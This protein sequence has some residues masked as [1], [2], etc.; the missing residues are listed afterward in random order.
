M[1]E[2]LTG[3]LPFDSNYDQSIIYSILNE[4]INHEKLKTQVPENIS[5]IV[6]KCLKKDKNERY[7]QV[8]ELMSEL[9]EIKKES[10]KIYSGIQP[11]LPDFLDDGYGDIISDK[12]I[13]VAREEELEK[14]GRFLDS[15]LSGKGR[16]VFVTGES[17]AGKTALVQKFSLYAQKMNPNLI[18]INGKCNAHTGF[19]DPYFPFIELL[20]LL[21]GDIESKYKAGVIS[22]E[23][24]LRLW[25]LTPATISAILENGAD[26]I[27]IFTNG[28]SLVSRA[29]EYWAGNLDW[30]I[31]LKKLVKYKS[32]LPA[33][34]TLQQRNI[35]EQYTRVIQSIAEEKPLLIVLNDLQWIDAGSANLFFHLARQI[36][37]SRILI[38]GLFRKTEIAIERDGKRHPMEP[39]FNELKRDYGEIEIDLDKIHGQKF[40]D[41]Y[42]DVEPN[43]LNVKF[44][45]T[46]FIQTKGHPLFT[47][48]L[49]REMKEHGMIVRDEAGR[50][51]EGKTFDWNRLP[52]RVDA[53]ITER[54]NRL[55]K[56]MRDIL[57][58]SCIQ[59]EE[60]A[61]EVTARFL[62]IDE[63]ELIRILSG[64]LE[65]LH[66]L[67]SAKGIKTL[68]KQRISM[69]IFRHIMFQ[70]YLYNSLDK[71]ERINL[72]EEVAKI[73]EE[74]YGEEVDEVS[75]QLAR[76]FQEAEIPEKAFEYLVKAGTRAVNFSA[77]EEIIFLFK[78]ALA[79]LQT[80]SE[81]AERDQYELSIQ[82]ALATAYQILIGFD[83]P[84]VTACCNRM[85]ELCEKMGDTPQNFY[86]QYFLAHI[87]WMLGNHN[88]A[89][90][91]T[92]QL[93]Q[94]AEKAKDAEKVSLTHCLQGSLSFYLGKLIPSLEHFKQMNSDYLTEKSSHLKCIV[95]YDPGLI[96]GINSACALWCLGYPDQANLQSQKMIK[97]ARLIDHSMNLVTCLSLDAIHRILRRDY[98]ICER[99]GEEIYGISKK[100]GFMLFIGGGLFKIGFA[101]INQ[102][103]VEE[104]IKKLHQ[105][106]EIYI[107]TGLG[108]TR[109]ELL[110]SFAEAYGKYGDI[111]RGMDFM[112]QAISLAQTGGEHYYEAELYRIKGELLL[113]EADKK[114]RKEIEKKAEEC[115]YQSITLAQKQMAKSFELR[116][117]TSL[118]RLLQKQ[119]KKKEAR[120]LLTNIYDWFTE[121]FETKDLIEAKNL[122]EDLK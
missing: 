98:S 66:Q 41:A 121:G 113:M 20:N 62:K 26:L 38:I 77:Y 61:A 116:S 88:K 96:S 94:Q 2:M 48:E 56:S 101:F 40:V 112:E 14:L 76:H 122:I 73:I 15:A 21:S 34:S 81:S 108:F 33:D 24:A 115:F 92:T 70:K 50:W 99:Q 13:L 18:V 106:L 109:T 104:G 29:S 31:Q 91:F 60:F 85:E 74:L 36:K 87:N 68:F 30:L 95:G 97:A 80:F 42:L 52:T 102:G 32:S 75:V 78:K 83:G 25:N 51:I 43:N 1:F 117:T 27:N 35:F 5:S 12:S 8:E 59:G 119:S 118:C 89:F 37:G 47:V 3:K 19:G 44:R 54:I 82:T 45:N 53:V 100:K 110:G 16:L 86:S 46:F 72:H 55:S 107:A 105:A 10:S 114:D 84:E 120:D 58:I 65:K 111:E 63:K 69:Y 28:K 57:L 17:G 67:V 71:I 23:H 90:N 64:E 93:M 103:K 39:I 9:R 4:E 49:F 7:Q 79:V 6:L 22:R 11:R